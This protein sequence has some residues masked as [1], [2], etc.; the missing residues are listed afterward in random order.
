MTPRARMTPALIALI[1]AARA[2]I[3]RDIG[4]DILSEIPV[5]TISRT[6]EYVD[7]PIR[8]PRAKSNHPRSWRKP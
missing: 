6:P 2:Q 1:G 3:A 4:D 5:V 8:E 7:K